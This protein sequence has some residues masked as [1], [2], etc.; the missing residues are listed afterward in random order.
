LP[1]AVLPEAER[2]DPAPDGSVEDLERAIPLDRLGLPP[3][4]RPETTVDTTIDAIIA[5]MTARQLIGQLLMP[6]YIYDGRGQPVTSMVPELQALIEEV[7]PGGF[8][9]FGENIR[10][11]EQVRALVA[12]VQAVAAIPMLI[13]I[14]QEGGVVRRL[15]PSEVMPA[16]AIPAAGRVGRS[17]DTDLAYELATVI[18]RELRSLGVTLNLAPVADVATNPGNPVIGSRA[19]GSDPEEVARIV[20]AT[21]DGLQ[22][23]GVSAALKHFPGHGDT[24]EDSHVAMAVLPHG[25]DRLRAVELV[26]FARGIAAGSD[27]VMTGHISVPELTGSDEPAT[28]SRRITYDLLREDLGF[29]GIVITDALTMA[30]LTRYFTAEEIPVR[31]LEAGADVLL[32]PAD[33]RRAADVITRAVSD[34]SIPI[35][36]IEASV[37]RIL[38]LKIRRGLIVPPVP[39]G[40]AVSGDTTTGD[41]VA[42][43]GETTAVYGPDDSGRVIYYRPV[44]FFPEEPVLGVPEHQAVVDEIMKRSAR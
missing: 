20:A 7:A 14:D 15:V 34:G 26:P 22:S 27:A 24:M 17:G 37:R 36:R 35:E 21:V 25:I 42:S 44:R 3:V 38:R 39:A 1:E 43:S 18:A 33:A 16:T 13:A 40:S 2:A 28:L 6:A 32:R 31:A 29:D 10:T 8:L 4:E 23:N 12:D 19:Y 5:S 9:L 11:P 30:G 41:S